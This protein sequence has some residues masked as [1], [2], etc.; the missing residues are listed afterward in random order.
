MLEQETRNNEVAHRIITFTD[1]GDR[2]VEFSVPPFSDKS[3]IAKRK[4]KN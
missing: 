1:F 3:H 4:K 2:F